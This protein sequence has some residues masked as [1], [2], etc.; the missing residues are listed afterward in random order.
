MRQFLWLSKIF[1]GLMLMANTCLADE[2][3]VDFEEDSVPVLNEEL[4]QIREVSE[5]FDTR[6]DTNE[7]DIDTNETDIST[8]QADIV[9]LE[10]DA[11]ASP[12][13]VWSAQ[14]WVNF[15]GK[16]TIAVN[17]SYNVSTVVDNAVGKY[18][19]NWDTDFAD[20]NY[21]CVFGASTTSAGGGPNLVCIEDGT[22][23]VG[24]IQ[25]NVTNA[26]DGDVDTGDI[27]VVAF[28]R[29]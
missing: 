8:S 18:T 17:D 21:C 11:V 1:I 27:S 22:K 29:Q 14:A 23:A 26:A 9:V 16:E 4:R 10:A 3:I 2:L 12:T 7:D 19:I 20:T 13:S 5:D 15:N 28:G 25:I 6:L 24:S